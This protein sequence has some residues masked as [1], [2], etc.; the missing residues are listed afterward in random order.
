[1]LGVNRKQQRG[2]RRAGVDGRDSLMRRQDL[3]ATTKM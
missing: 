2:W 3:E 1:M